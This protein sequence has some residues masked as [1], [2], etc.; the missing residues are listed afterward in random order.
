MRLTTEC[1][2]GGLCVSVCILAYT[3]R[4][5]DAGL[6]ARLKRVFARCGGD[7]GPAVPGEY[8]VQFAVTNALLLPYS[9]ISDRPRVYPVWHVT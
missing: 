4:G 2:S 8:V 9:A 6:R 5:D 3:R 7:V 1:D